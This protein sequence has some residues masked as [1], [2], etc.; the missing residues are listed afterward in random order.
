MKWYGAAGLCAALCAGCGLG[1]GSVVR[2]VDGQEIQGRAI[3]TDAYAAYTRGMLFE[4]AEKYSEAEREYLLA[5][6]SDPS[7]PEL[8]SR[9][10]A[11]RCHLAGRTGASDALARAQQLDPEYGPLFV[12]KAE[13]ARTE[14]NIRGALEHARKAV[15]LDPKHPA[16]L[17][18]L[19]STLTAAGKNREALDWAI[20][21][22]LEHGSPSAWQRVARLSDQ[23]SDSAWTKHASDRARASRAAMAR[24]GGGQPSCDDATLRELDG[25]LVAGKL[26]HAR[27]LANR[28]RVTPG[29]LASRAAALGATKVALTQALHVLAADPA[30]GDARVALWVA[31]DLSGDSLP[32]PPLEGAAVPV[33]PLSVRLMAEMLR[34]RTGDEAA[35]AWIAAA[36]ALPQARDALERSIDERLRRGGITL[37]PAQGPTP[38][39][40]LRF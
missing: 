1:S 6:E 17:E 38:K 11:V 30:N 31:A 27:D 39:R 5:V 28:C 10:G 29:V 4:L 21:L 12:A 34:R 32:E 14:G 20:A 16:A 13:C 19:L 40:R 22:A 15:T 2:V 8:W 18:T 3:G 25:A 7:S 24:G 33:G 26:G 37:R 23:L 36:P 9:L 35:R